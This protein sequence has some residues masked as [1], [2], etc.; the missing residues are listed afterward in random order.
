MHT[1][2]LTVNTQER[3]RAIDRSEE[4][5]IWGEIARRLMDAKEATSGHRASVMISKLHA[6][7]L[8]HPEALW[9]VVSLLTG[10]L[11]EIT[12][13]YAEM[14]REHAKSKQA[15]E[16]ERSR[17]LAGIQRHFPQLAK[18]VI[19]LRHITAEIDPTNQ[20]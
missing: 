11:S 15:I 9:L 17:A 1:Q 10:D 4:A 18:A 6:L 8:I 14:G 13:S 2:I 5:A 20:P 3:S 12:K 16:Q 19:Q 7:S